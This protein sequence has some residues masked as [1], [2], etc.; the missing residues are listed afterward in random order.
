VA[1]S[2][3]SFYLFASPITY[4]M[5]LTNLVTDS[6]PVKIVFTVA[7][8]CIAQVPIAIVGFSYF[9]RLG[10]AKAGEIIKSRANTDQ[11]LGDNSYDVASLTAIDDEASC[12]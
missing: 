9:L 12:S 8:S 1:I 2:F 7:T 3:V 11:N 5:A 4:V 6:I 10:W